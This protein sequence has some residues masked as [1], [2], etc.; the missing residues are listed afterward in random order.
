MSLAVGLQGWQS[1]IYSGKKR[2]KSGP[3]VIW[4]ADHEPIQILGLKA[5]VSKLVGEELDSELL[6]FMGS[7]GCFCTSST[8]P[9]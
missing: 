2:G 5:G 6:S 4:K 7:M 3:A 8:L 9:L 1:V